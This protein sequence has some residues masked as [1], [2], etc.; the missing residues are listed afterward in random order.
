MKSIN[1]SKLKATLLAV[2]DEVERTGEVVEIKKRG[3]VVAA[4]VPPT[5]TARRPQDSLL[6]SVEI[7]GDIVGPLGSA[8]EWDAESER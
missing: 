7:T 5:R 1:A 2:L 4:L 3:R 6:G 8:S